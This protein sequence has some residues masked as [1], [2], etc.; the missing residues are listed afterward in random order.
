MNRLLICGAA[1]IAVLASRASAHPTDLAFASFG[2]CNAAL[3]QQDKTDRER[4]GWFFPSNG[5]AE[6]AMLNNWQC[7]YDPATQAWHFEGQPLGGHD[8][9]NGNGKADPG[10]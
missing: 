1:G 6:V 8:L 10:Y 5:A 7:E 2:E 4:V 3:H 9:G